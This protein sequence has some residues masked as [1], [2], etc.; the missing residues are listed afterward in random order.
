MKKRILIYAILLDALIGQCLHAQTYYWPVVNGPA[1]LTSAFGPRNKGR[2]EYPINNSVTDRY[3][4]D[5]HPALDLAIHQIDNEVVPVL[6]GIVDD[7]GGSGVNTYVTIEHTYPGESTTFLCTYTH[8]TPT[9]GLEEG[10]LVIGG[11]DVI[12]NT[13][14]YNGGNDHTADHLDLRYFPDGIR[15][16]ADMNGDNPG[17]ILTQTPVGA[18]LTISTSEPLILNG[19]ETVLP[20]TGNQLFLEADPT[21]LFGNQV[22]ARYFVIGARIPKSALSI[23][24]IKVSLC[25][26]YNGDY[27]DEHSLLKNTNATGTYEFEEPHEVTYY[28]GDHWETYES[29]TVACGD[30]YDGTTTSRDDGHNSSAV[31]IYPR[32]LQR[33]DTY[34]TVYF[35]WYVND[36]YWSYMNYINATI[37]VNTWVIIDNKPLGITRYNIP[38]GRTISGY[39]TSDGTRSGSPI[40][41]VIMR[42][43]SYEPNTDATGKYNAIVPDGWSGTATPEFA[44]FSFDPPNK[45]YTNITTDQTST[46]ED[47]RAIQNTTYTI[48]GYV[49]TAELATIKNV[50]MSGLPIDTYTDDNGFYSITVSSGWTG[51]VIPVLAGYSFQPYKRDYSMTEDKTTED[52]TG[53]FQTGPKIT[54]SG[55]VLKS[56]GSAM[57]GVMIIADGNP[58]KSTYT[59]GDGTYSI[60]EISPWTGTIIPMY[61][62]YSFTPSSIALSGVTTNQTAKDF[63]GYNTAGSQITISGTIRKEDGSAIPNVTVMATGTPINAIKNTNE[64]GQY[65]LI[66]TKSWSGTVYPI[67]SGY[68][69]SPASQVYDGI[70]SDQSKDYTGKVVTSTEP[71]IQV[72]SIQPSE[73]P[74]N[75]REVIVNITYSNQLKYPNCSCAALMRVYIDGEQRSYVDP[76]KSGTHK[77]SYSLSSGTH[78]IHFDQNEC[79][80]D[81]TPSEHTKDYY[82][83]FIV[84]DG[85]IPVKMDQLGEGSVRI[86]KL[87]TWNGSIFDHSID[88]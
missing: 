62:G 10:N 65:T 67:L 19:S 21:D 35:R 28:V 52:Y 23:N 54:I 22:N 6:S 75:A 87:G 79:G 46:N 18:G 81:I 77:F 40:S 55:T 66:L 83:T 36:N 58:M 33:G 53:S 7:I 34:H 56:N 70:S 51:T 37:E 11:L 74:Y 29:W 60:E 42:N 30:N 69:F 24:S 47:Y 84:T 63:T 82:Y 13:L 76:L 41:G 80:A 14:C 32:R 1:T 59:V 20:E 25:G 2:Q 73:V 44:K 43:I 57:S 85:P 50:H 8:I 68:S 5:F 71:N 88:P 38:I 27:L 61:S 17:K 49:R 26:Y 12:G 15:A 31:G 64:Y 4:Y 39:I 45:I 72:L 86:G 78:I 16:D 3:E 9:A 48:S